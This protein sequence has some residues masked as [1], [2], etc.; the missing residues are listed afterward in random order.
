MC[1]SYIPDKIM[2][3][4]NARGIIAV[5]QSKLIN[6]IL[7]SIKVCMLIQS[8]ILGLL[9]ITKKKGSYAYHDHTPVTYYQRLNPLPDFN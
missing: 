5:L 7:L 2:N 8:C 6:F 9:Y 3:R 1:A 4:L